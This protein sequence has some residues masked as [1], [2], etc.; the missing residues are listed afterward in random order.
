MYLNDLNENHNF[1]LKVSNFLY[2]A[3]TQ[4]SMWCILQILSG[5][6]ANIQ[7]NNSSVTILNPSLTKLFLSFQGIFVMIC[8][9]IIFI[10][11]LNYFRN[12][13]LSTITMG[14]WK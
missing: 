12:L 2:Q 13:L 6:S 9:T 1:W 14:K 11:G 3:L 7:I 4:I 8:L 5:I 10:M